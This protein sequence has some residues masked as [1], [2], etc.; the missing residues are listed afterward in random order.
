MP[1]SP[2]PKSIDPVYSRTVGT[3]T[4]P[5]TKK[6][7]I[8]DW[9]S[10]YSELKLSM[11]PMAPEDGATWADFLVSCNGIANVFMLPTAVANL[12]PAGMTPG[13]YWHMKYNT[14]RW[15][16]TEGQTYELEFEIR[17]ALP[18]ANVTLA[19]VGGGTV[20]PPG[21]I[22][23]PLNPSVQGGQWLR[24]GDGNQWAVAT[25]RSLMAAFSGLTEWQA[26][27]I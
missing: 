22:Q 6:Q 9:Q 8:Q 3:S 4:N 24:Y 21:L 7:Q 27:L 23:V 18:G 11:P 25:G 20:A 12:L 16:I 17:E 2:A 5:F 1:T 10:N 19:P 26:N 13:G 15:A 14:A